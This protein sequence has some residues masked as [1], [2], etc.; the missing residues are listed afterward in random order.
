ME[1][2]KTILE[3]W[4]SD[5]EFITV[6]DHPAAE[7][8]R[9]A[10]QAAAGGGHMEIVKILLDAG[11]PINAEAAETSGRTA[12]QAA[13]EGG[14]KE[15]VPFLIDNGANVNG[16]SASNYG[17][18]ALEAAAAHR[19]IEI[20][21]LLLK[22]KADVN[23]IP[24][25][26]GRTPLQAAAEVGCNEVI[27][28]LLAQGANIHAPP[29]DCGGRSAL[30]GAA[31]KGHLK[32]VELLLDNGARVDDL[33]AKRYGCTALYGAVCSG[34]RDI[35]ELLLKSR[36]TTPGYGASSEM[37][38]ALYTAVER[39]HDQAVKILLVKGAPIFA[40]ETEP[41][42][43]TI[44]QAALH[45]GDA[46]IIESILTAPF[47]LEAAIHYAL[48]K[49]HE[50]VTSNLLTNDKL[51]I[52]RSDGDNGLPPLLRAVAWNHVEVIEWLVAR[53]G[54]N[55]NSKDNDGNTALSIAAE[56]G[57]DLIVEKL[58]ERQF[59][60]NH[61]NNQGLTPLTLASSNCHV[62]VVQALLANPRISPKILSKTKCTCLLAAVASNGRRGV[63]E[64]KIK[65]VVEM[66]LGHDSARDLENGADES[67]ITPLIMA[68][69]CGLASIIETL[70]SRE[71]IHIN[72]EDCH[73]KTAF[74]TASEKKDWAILFLLLNDQ[75]LELD[76][77]ILEKYISEK[78]FM[79]HEALNRKA[80]VLVR[81]L[82]KSPHIKA[83]LNATNTKGET[84]LMIAVRQKRRD[85]VAAL[86][87]CESVELGE[88]VLS[89]ETSPEVK[90]FLKDHPRGTNREK[91]NP[92]APGISTAHTQGNSPNPLQE[93]SSRRPSREP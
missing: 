24:S 47:D 42:G 57:S 36:T 49:G 60:I 71:G 38:R 72:A 11:A 92:S 21:N 2:V 20:V 76:S 6:L 45:S 44:L 63:T 12:L 7:D 53:D 30:Q 69:T 19:N 40:H 73:H 50:D 59:H 14:Q 65:S 86:L 34:K 48:I 80:D 1:V 90:K 43:K 68:A 27:K 5:R 41:E 82:L 62:E 10:L 55:V 66:I 67:G 51:D 16:K 78:P 87:E 4:G 91:T 52:N 61:A 74:S 28:L 22:K 9:T 35:V 77:E 83:Q 17:I 37:R 93:S 70:L 26:Y 46:G 54:L 32:A 31:E 56:A 58:L 8:G 64:E 84:P 23:P 29:G 75:R 39:G 15:I 81:R 25:T 88:T 85:I 79:L 3:F 33:P 89:M 18:T 13:I